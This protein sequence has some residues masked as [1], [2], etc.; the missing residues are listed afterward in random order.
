MGSL[1]EDI[2][3][4][5]NTL[6]QVLHSKGEELLV[7]IMRNSNIGIRET[8]Y[9]NWNSGTYG[10][11]LNLQVPVGLYGRIQDRLEMIE[12]EI[13]QKLRPLTR[14]YDNEYLSELII[15]PKP[16]K[17]LIEKRNDGLDSI[18]EINIEKP[19]FWKQGYLSLFLSHVSQQKEVASKLQ[20]K[21]EDYAISAF[22]AHEDIEPNQKWQD[23]IEL[24]LSSMDALVAL[25]TNGFRESKWCDQEVG[26]AIG[27]KVI[28][29]PVRYEIDPYGFI[30]KIQGIS[31]N[32]KNVPTI[33]DEIFNV[34]LND[35]TTKR[36]MTEAIVY[37]LCNSCGFKESIETM[38]LLERASENL[39]SEMKDK[40]RVAVQNN[41]QII[42]AFD[43]PEKINLIIN[44]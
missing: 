4:I 41:S 3:D 30:G 38:K 12:E 32:K 6:A 8:S 43:V 24:A 28:V 20:E 16:I 44:R 11:T 19:S 23:K 18:G 36:R 7:E 1:A 26:V 5:V 22:V 33:C 25:L 14:T 40:L 42:K 21:L 2:K 39:T 10:Y 15:E 29:L 31:A 37:K 13:L 34:L 17:S 35:S 9:D 27:R